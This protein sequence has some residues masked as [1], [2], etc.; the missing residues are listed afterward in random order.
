[1]AGGVEAA[2]AAVSSDVDR[3]VELAAALRAELVEMRG[4]SLWAATRATHMDVAPARAARHYAELAEGAGTTLVVGT[5][6][7]VVVG[8]GTARVE[9]L[10]DGRRVA[11]IDEVYVE[12]GAREVGVGEVVLDA[13]GAWAA[14]EHCDGVDAFALPGH[15]AAKN[16]FEAHGF[17]ARLLVMHRGVDSAR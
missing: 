13:L 10:G 16:F 6:D 9:V 17:R 2:R 7:G 4:G 5:I 11:T 15:R 8:Y 1:M 12:P 3:V 14:A